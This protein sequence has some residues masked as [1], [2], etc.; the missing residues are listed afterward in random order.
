MNARGAIWTVTRSF[1]T[2]E[3]PALPLSSRSTSEHRERLPRL[4][5]EDLLL[6]PQRVERGARRVRDEKRLRPVDEDQ[7]EARNLLLG[8]LREGWGGAGE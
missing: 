7:P 1:G 5:A 6:R 3:A 8:E 4:E 2:V